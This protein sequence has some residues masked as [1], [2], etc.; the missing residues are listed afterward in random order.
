MEENFVPGPE[1]KLTL[2]VVTPGAASAGPDATSNNNASETTLRIRSHSCR[3]YTTTA[4]RRC[5]MFAAH[6]TY[7]TE[8]LGWIDG[9]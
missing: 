9:K 2:V 1:R 5:R 6:A 4:P 7:H 8:A 3:S